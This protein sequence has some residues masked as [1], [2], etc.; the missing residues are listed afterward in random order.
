MTKK[1]IPLAPRSSFRTDVDYM[2]YLTEVIDYVEGKMKA[3]AKQFTKGLKDDR[4]KDR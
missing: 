2:L 3:A 4:S 1:Y